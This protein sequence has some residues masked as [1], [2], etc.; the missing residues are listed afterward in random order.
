ML[1]AIAKIV[2]E[3]GLGLDVCSEGEL[4]TALQAGVAP[5]RCT[6]HG[7]A[8][9]AAELELAARS[10]LGYIVVDN[11]AEIESLARIAQALRARARV[12]VRINVAVAAPTKT[13]VQ[14][15]SVESKFGFPIGDGQALAAVE[16][17]QRAP[18]LD[19]CGVHCHIGS[20]II[21]FDAY[22]EAIDRLARF[23]Q[24]ALTERSI[25]CEAFNVGGGLGVALDDHALA[26]S[27]EAWADAIFAAMETHFPGKRQ[28]R[29][30]LMVEPGRALISGAGTS[31]YTVAVRKTLPNGSQ[32]LIVDGGMSDNPRPALYEAQ[33]RVTLVSRTDAE[34]DGSYTV[35]GRHCETD[36]LFRDVPLPHPQPGDILAVANA[37]AYTYSMASNY[38]RFARPAVVLVDGGT[39]RLIA[40]REP[41]EHVLDLDVI[42][43]PAE[44]LHVPE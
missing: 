9:T 3:E 20:Q 10:G 4:L 37:G 7:C 41:L 38:N 44:P 16:A 30:R 13:S 1:K 28:K 42:D 36:L 24:T 21:D 22:A 6:L 39:A 5:Q 8:K 19:F 17:V 11:E 32:A 23:V 34:A 25:P 15:S 27:P 26:P 35:F 43:A 31:L 33:Y 12:L 2:D 29:P 14:T 18:W 40:R